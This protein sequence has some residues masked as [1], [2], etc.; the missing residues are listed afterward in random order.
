MQN[1]T[2]SKE[3]SYD[4]TAGKAYV[5]MLGGMKWDEEFANRADGIAHAHGLSQ[6]AWD[7]LVRE[8][9]WKMKWIFTPK[10]YTWTGRFMLAMYFLNPFSKK[11]N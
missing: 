1:T 8:Y 6:D 11:E 7:E 9:A 10:N 3:T 2:H 4:H 5:E